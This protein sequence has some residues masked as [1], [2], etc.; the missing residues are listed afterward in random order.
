MLLQV[1]DSGLLGEGV[2]H[3]LAAAKQ[4]LLTK[5]AA[6]V[7]AGATV[8]CQVWFLMR[9]FYVYVPECTVDERVFS[10]LIS[11]CSF[12]KPLP[13]SYYFSTGPA[14][15]PRAGGGL[16]HAASQQVAMAAGL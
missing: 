11:Y 7:P 1:F 16:R 2:L 13:I 9:P 5:D 4:K 6:L 12:H 15:A 10:S 8:Y 3:M 14:D